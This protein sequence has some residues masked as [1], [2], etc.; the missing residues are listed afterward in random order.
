MCMG[1]NLLPLITFLGM[2]NLVRSSMNGEES[3]E[4]LLVVI[5]S[6]RSSMNGEESSTFCL[7]MRNLLRSSVDE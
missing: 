5:N 4:S 6:L 3:F 7:V 2:R 1:R